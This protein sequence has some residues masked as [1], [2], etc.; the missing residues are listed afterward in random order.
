MASTLTTHEVK[1]QPAV[2]PQ[3]KIVEAY[4]LRKSPKLDEQVAVAPE[5]SPKKKGRP[6]GSKN[7][8]KGE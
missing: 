4:G 2:I 8:P 1:P 3:T 6:K 7:K 5:P